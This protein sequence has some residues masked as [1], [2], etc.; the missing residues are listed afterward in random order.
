MILKSFIVVCDHCKHTSHYYQMKKYLFMNMTQMHVKSE[1]YQT[2]QN[3]PA[4][5]K[6]SGL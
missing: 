5:K 6:S 2:N 1:I 3:S 4:I